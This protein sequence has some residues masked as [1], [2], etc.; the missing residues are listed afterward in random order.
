MQEQIYDMLLKE[1]EVTWQDIIYKLVKD[2][3]MDPWDVDLHRLTHKYIATVKGLKEMNYFISGKVLLA[4]AI[5]LKIKSNRLVQEDINNFDAFLFHVDEPLAFE[6]LGEFN[7]YHEHK[8]EI[9]QLGVRTPQARRRKVSISDL[10]GA[11]EKALRVD[12]RRKLR[13]QKFLNFHRPEIPEKKIDIN[14]LIDAIYQKLTAYF[15]QR[16]SVPFSE[17]RTTQE[18]E[19]TILTLLPLLYLHNQNKVNL[20]QEEAFSEIHIHN[21]LS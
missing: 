15:K 14:K 6:E 3:Q 10:I 20:E 21:F 1:N 7:P 13:L 2:E 11:L 5:L 4:S 17:L 9:P 12:S 18:K 8:V 16:K 19:E